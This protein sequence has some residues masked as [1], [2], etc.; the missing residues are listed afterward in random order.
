ML[1][2]R[3]TKALGAFLS[4]SLVAAGLMLLPA[5][6][7]IAEPVPAGGVWT[8]EYFPSGDGTML[9]ADIIRP[10]GYTNKDK[11][12]VIL[13]IGPYF[14]TGSGSFPVPTPQ[15]VGPINRFPE[16]FTEGKILQRGYTWVQVDLR[17]H[18]GSDGCG[19]LGGPGEQMDVK[20]AVEWAAKQPW[21]TGKVGMWGKSYDAW[22]QT[23][24]LATKPKG[25]AAAVIQSPIIEGYRTFYMNGVHYD[26]G[27][28]A[29]PGLYAGYD[30]TP[31][32]V[33]A[34]ADSHIY[35]SKGTATNPHCYALNQVGALTDDESAQYWK[36]RQLI[37]RAKGSKTPVLFSHG[38]L[39]ANTKPDNFMDIWTNLR[40]PKRAWF[41]QYDHV[42]G[43]ESNL[44]G[45]DGFL[46]EAMRWFDRY[47]KGNKKAG[48]ERDP[49]VEIQ[50]GEGRW[51]AEKHWP[52]LDAKRYSMPLKNGVYVDEDGNNADGPSSGNGTWSVSQKLPYDIHLAGETK[53]TVNVETV[54][55]NAHLVGLL[56]DIDSKGT[57]T[58]IT[59]G[60][61]LIREAG[62]VS[63]K[64]YPQDWRLKKGHRV[65][66]LLSGSDD[67]WFMPGVSG[68]DVTVSKG[69]VSMPFL[70]YDRDKFLKGGPAEAMTSRTPFA[71]EADVLKTRGVKAK[72]PPKLKG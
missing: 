47:L 33:N 5:S 34:P 31:N 72:L 1:R 28:Y 23:M 49:G 70:R 12:P 4:L 63:F 52:P 20:A 67:S 17:G 65:G 13:S 43:N 7:A 11:T 27:W 22:T 62:K 15:R 71:V 48:V 51:R 60:A 68:T 6:P 36:D 59:R 32:S 19:D 53:L 40:G 37:K 55:P 61:Y 14:G 10:K 50:S 39:D 44:V 42:R 30:V 41:G 46:D 24:A 9:H 54:V 66:F 57:A 18:G 16:V 35:A 69:S 2:G 8:Q 58:I 56:Y 3:K 26:S 25:L 21:S 29:T 45:R 64:L 38:F